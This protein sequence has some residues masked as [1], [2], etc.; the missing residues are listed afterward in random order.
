MYEIYAKLQQNN[1]VLLG[2]GI[3]QNSATL[4]MV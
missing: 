1:A 4:L 2:G 3:V